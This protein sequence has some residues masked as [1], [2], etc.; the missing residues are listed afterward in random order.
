MSCQSRF[1]ARYWMLGAGALGRPRGGQD[2]SLS[3]ALSRRLSVKRVCLLTHCSAPGLGESHGQAR[4]CSRAELWPRFTTCVWTAS[5]LLLA[6]T[7]IQSG[8]SPWVRRL[9]FFP[10]PD[11]K[12]HTS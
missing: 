2:R 6:P 1:D 9:F 3:P 12:P 4:H 11:I 8:H 10:E 5:R 7:S